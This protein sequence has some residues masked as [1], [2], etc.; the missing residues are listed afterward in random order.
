MLQD[1]EKELK[2]KQDK[3][4]A[5]ILQG[6]FKTGKG[7]YGEGDI[8]LGIVVP[9]QRE[10]AKKFKNLSLE[11]IQIL[12]N[13]KIHEK[14]LIA[15]LI[16]IERYKEADEKDKKNIFNF[17]LNNTKSIN[18]WDLVDLSAPNIIGDY[19]LKRDRKILYPLA[20]SNNLWQKRIAIIST[21]AFIRNK[22]YKD[23]INLAEILLKDKHDLIHKAV[24]WMLREI[25]K[26]NK[27]ELI[28]FLNKYYKIM[29]RTML[30]YSIEK[31]D[32]KERG[33]YLER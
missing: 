8:F 15:L 27:E 16:L 21:F 6:F 18:N 14:R 29:P 1:L 13:S 20:K 30:R 19:L 4:K 10:I 24:G 12:L 7:E 25:G 11:D 32:E 2:R 31:L 22:E 28:K 3:E 33:F 17:Y 26:R 5:K 9:K 23:T